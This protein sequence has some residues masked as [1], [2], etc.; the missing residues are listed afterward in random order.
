MGAVTALALG[1]AA[2]GGLAGAMGGGGSQ[3]STVNAGRAT[4]LERQGVATTRENLA[5]LRDLV[6]EGPG[7]GD[8]RAGLGAQRDLAS[9]FSQLQQSGG[10]PGQQDIAQAGGFAQ[11]I[12]DPQ[13]VAMQ[14]QMEDQRQMMS[15]QAALLGR[16]SSDPILQARLASQQGD[17]A[18]LLNA[19]QG[20]F[21]SQLALQLPG[22]RAA[23]ATQRANILGGLATQAMQNRQALASLGQ[24]ITGQERN[25]R[26]NTASRTTTE[27]VSPGQRFSNAISGAFGGAGMGMGLSSMMGGGG[28]G[29]G[30][31]SMS[32]GTPTMNFVSNAPAPQQ[33]FAPAPNYSGPTQGLNSTMGVQNI[34]FGSNALNHPRLRGAFN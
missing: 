1:G 7:Q 8:V 10:L 26:L 12:F 20:A 17:R 21:Q 23:F 27:N 34:S 6:S 9:L 28:G 2:L 11:S 5:Q 19:Q 14:Q 18:A 33:S 3:T 32:F 25:F 30:G 13:R 24:S 31:A 29:G 4:G 15:R 16:D 22:Q